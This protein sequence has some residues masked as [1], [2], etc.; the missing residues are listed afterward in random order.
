MSTINELTAFLR[1]EADASRVPAAITPHDSN[2]ALTTK[3]IP[4]A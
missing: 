2:G 4:V 3:D 1:R